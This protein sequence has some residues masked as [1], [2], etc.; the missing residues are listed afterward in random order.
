MYDVLRDIVCHRRGTDDITRS[1]Q[2]TD[3]IRKHM[4]YFLENHDEQRIASN[5]FAGDGNKAVP[6][7]IVAALLE[8]NPFMLYA[9]QEYG[10]RG[11]DEEGFSGCDGRTTI[12]DYWSVDTLTRAAAH[13]LT[14]EEQALASIY[15]KVLAIA[16]KE[17]AISDGKMFDLM[18]ANQ[19][20]GGQYAFLRSGVKNT[21]LVVVN[22]ED[23]PVEMLLTIPAHAFD[24]LSLT[25][26]TYKATDLLTGDKQSLTLQ[27]DG[28][29]A[30]SMQ[31]RS[32]VILKF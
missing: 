8:Q 6:A 15:N 11:M 19:S 31:A 4:L 16:R 26:K 21:L 28:Q 24:Y 12:F 7:L 29:V 9:G 14:S 18:Y 27:R 5:F 32:G 23:S 17:Q 20:Y 30:I 2:H 10:E 13:Q 22:F 25:E 1:W 3:D